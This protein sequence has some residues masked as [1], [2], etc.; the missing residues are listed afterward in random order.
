MDSSRHL[1]LSLVVTALFLALGVV[2]EALLGFRPPGWMEDELRR[3]FLRL[4]H[5]HG[6]ILGM[7]NVAIAWAVERLQTPTPWARRTRV[8]ALLGALFVGFGF[9]GGG[10]WHGR[11]DPGPLVLLVP[12]GALL[13]LCSLVAIAVVRPDPTA[14]EER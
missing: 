10:L 12:A 9:V 2:I 8:A 4:G 3:E 13:L 5:A 7:L 11:T 1:R 6:A 14:S